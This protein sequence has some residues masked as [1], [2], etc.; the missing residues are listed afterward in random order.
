M[1]PQTLTLLFGALSIC[2]S[3]CVVGYILLRGR[4]SARRAPAPLT[5]SKL[6]FDDHSSGRLGAGRAADSRRKTLPASTPDTCIPGRPDPDSGKSPVLSSFPDT[7]RKT[8]CFAPHVH[9]IFARGDGQGG[10]ADAA[11]KGVPTSD[12]GAPAAAGADAQTGAVSE[13]ER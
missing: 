9:D 5:A 7:P 11:G 2:V 3:A 13:S 6:V 1:N 10:E 4:K 8:T 12:S